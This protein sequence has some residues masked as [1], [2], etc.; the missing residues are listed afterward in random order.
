MLTS[1]QYWNLT[2][3]AHDSK[4]LVAFGYTETLKKGFGSVM[5]FLSSMTHSPAEK[6]AT[7]IPAKNMCGDSNS[8]MVNVIH[9]ERVGPEITET[10]EEKVENPSLEDYSDFIEY[11]DEEELVALSKGFNGQ[12]KGNEDRLMLYNE[13]VRRSERQRLRKE[14]GWQSTQKAHMSLETMIDKKQHS[15]DWKK[16]PDGICVLIDYKPSS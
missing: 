12:K 7:Q 6:L 13:N 9:R 4:E 11:G 16:F 1:I 15:I 3:T 8:A 5:D 2:K 10:Y 14:K